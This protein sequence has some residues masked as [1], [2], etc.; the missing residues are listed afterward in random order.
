MNEALKDAGCYTMNLGEML[1]DLSTAATFEGDKVK[2]SY[3]NVLQLIQILHD[4]IAETLQECEGKEFVITLP[5]GLIA[6]IQCLLTSIISPGFNHT[7][8]SGTDTTIPRL[9]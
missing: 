7:S 8:Y 2:V 6:I 4:N 1:T 5:K 9:W 3:T